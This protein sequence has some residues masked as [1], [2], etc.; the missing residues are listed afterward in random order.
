MNTFYDSHEISKLL[1]KLKP[2]L[3]VTTKSRYVRLKLRNGHGFDAK[4]LGTTLTTGNGRITGHGCMVH[5]R[6]LDQ[7]WDTACDLN[8]I[9]E[10]TN[11]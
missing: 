6:L 9:V 5:Y 2:Y 8:E 3:I 11:I 1:T 10:M 4:Y 7:D